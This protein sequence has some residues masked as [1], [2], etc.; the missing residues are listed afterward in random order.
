MEGHGMAL[1]ATA[2]LHWKPVLALRRNREICLASLAE[3]REE[4][5]WNPKEGIRS[6]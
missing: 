3:L 1:V 2:H 4:R 5:S 6:N